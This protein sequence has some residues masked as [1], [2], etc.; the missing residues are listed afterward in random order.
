MPSGTERTIFDE[1]QRGDFL[2]AIWA[3]F[4]ELQLMDLQMTNALINNSNSVQKG[5]NNNL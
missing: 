3:V 2:G 1:K 4:V 5:Q